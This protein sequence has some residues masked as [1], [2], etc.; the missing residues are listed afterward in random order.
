[1]VI[2]TKYINHERY[3]Q[4]ISLDYIIR[5]GG[6]IY[7]FLSFLDFDDIILEIEKLY[8][9]KPKYNIKGM[10]MLAISYHI[11]KLGYKNTIKDVSALDR[12]ILNFKNGKMP[13]KSKLCDFVTKTMTPKLLE[14]LMFKIGFNLYNYKS[15]NCLIKIANFDSTPIEASRYDKYAKYN[16]H[17]KCNMYKSHILMFGEIPLYM[18]FTNGTTNDKYIMPEFFEK[19]KSLNFK[20]HEMNLDGAYDGL[21]IY[22][23]IW[24]IFGAKPNIALRKDA[25]FNYKADIKSIDKHINKSWKKGMNITKP[26]NE[27]L[28][29]LFNDGKIDLVGSYLRNEVI[30]NGVGF[31]YKFRNYQERTHNA[32]KKTVKFDVKYMHN[33]NKEL[34]ILWSFISYQ[35]LCLTAIQ[36]NIKSTTFGFLI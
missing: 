31:S 36:N 9:R 25:V 28:N 12:D 19:I 10:L 27:K 15:N 3:N 1:M 22:A 35:L 13:S 21:Y 7:Q 14:K 6:S 8:V 26:L 4:E 29:F 16:I 17:Y 20:F 2:N 5:N 11:K 34:H 23:Y 18:K 33:K 32:I 30:K 24:S